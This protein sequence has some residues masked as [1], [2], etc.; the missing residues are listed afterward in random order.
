M[1]IAVRPSMQG[2]DAGLQDRLGVRID[3]GGRFVKAEDVRL[4]E[5]RPRKADQ[6]TLADAEVR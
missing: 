1:M 6:L 3:A 5:H 4:D 2:R